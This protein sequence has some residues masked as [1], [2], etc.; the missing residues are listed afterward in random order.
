M[1]ES[2]KKSA[3]VLTI[4]LPALSYIV[5]I[6]VYYWLLTGGRYKAFMQPKLWPLLILALTLLVLFAGW[7]IYR[8]AAGHKA[9]AGADTWL[10]AGI[11]LVP[12]LFLWTMYGHSLGAHALVNKNFD[13]GALSA[14]PETAGAPIPR[15]DL[16]AV[17]VSLLDL[18]KDAQGFNGRTVIT[19]GMIFHEPSLPDDTVMVFRFVIFCCAADALPIRVIV[20]T[21]AAGRLENETWVQVQGVLETGKSGGREIPTIIADTV[22]TIPTPSPE[23]RYLFL[24]NPN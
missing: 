20:H 10:R 21:D 14:L 15:A 24:Y 3:G 16:P 2:V 17:E 12:A 5:W 18:V 4:L 7:V 1:R 11:L 13:P 8:F 9:S 22:Q 23:N 6:D 19:E